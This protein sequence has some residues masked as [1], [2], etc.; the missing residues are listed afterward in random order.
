MVAVLPRG[1]III[2]VVTK[3]DRWKISA[4][5]TLHAEAREAIIQSERFD[6]QNAWRCREFCLKRNVIA[7]EA[8]RPHLSIKMSSRLV[9]RSG[10][11]DQAALFSIYR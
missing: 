4:G 7:F 5:M 8:E 11:V 1:A 6:G 9:F 2:I 10:D 3:S